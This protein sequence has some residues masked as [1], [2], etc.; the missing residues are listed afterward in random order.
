[1]VF[2]L[3]DGVL[4][5]SPA[6]VLPALFG[7]GPFIET[8]NHGCKV[9]TQRI[10]GAGVVDHNVWQHHDKWVCHQWRVVHTKWSG[11]K[12]KG[13][14][15]RTFIMVTPGG[16]IDCTS[17]S[18]WRHA[19]FKEILIHKKCRSVST[20][21]LDAWV[22]EDFF[23]PRSHNLVNNVLVIIICWRSVA[24]LWPAARGKYMYPK[25]CYRYSNPA[26]KFVFSHF[27][28]LIVRKLFAAG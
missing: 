13:S 26:F 19:L 14:P 3:N 8:R 2:G 9:V 22:T 4:E 6:Y 25:T 18:S 24:S 1:M 15:W 11:L 17:A 20:A 16:Q 7:Y 5:R 12:P 10:R 28:W 27:N 21:F 23:D